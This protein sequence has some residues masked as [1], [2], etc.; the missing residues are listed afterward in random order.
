MKSIVRSGD[1]QF[2]RLFVEQQCLDTPTFAELVAV[3]V[4]KSH[5]VPRVAR[6]TTQRLREA[7][8]IE[9]DRRL[10]G[11]LIHY[12]TR[13]GARFAGLDVPCGPVPLSQLAHSRAV[14]RVRVLYGRS[15]NRWTSEVLLRLDG[16]S[17]HLPDGLVMSPVSG[18]V[19]IVEVELTQKSKSRTRSILEDLDHV[20][21]H[22]RS[23]QVTGSGVHPVEIHYW[24]SAQ[25]RD[26][27]LRSLAESQIRTK[28][29]VF[30]TAT[31]SELPVPHP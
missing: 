12:A 10:S 2:A 3:T 19:A 30:D 4:G 7:G 8:F 5:M 23:G 6:R 9:A 13:Q 31:G 28:W 24:V 22:W 14:S 20:A 21:L 11:P 15:G 1:E 29:R 16:W 18:S 26:H 17:D 25:T 27:M